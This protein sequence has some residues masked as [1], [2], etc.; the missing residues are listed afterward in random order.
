MP[1]H[2][3]RHF[4]RFTGRPGEHRALARGVLHQRDVVHLLDIAS[5]GALE[6]AAHGLSQKAVEIATP[7]GFPITN[8]MIVT[9]GVAILLVVFAQLSTRRMA[10]V[11]SGA[12]NLFEWLVE[13]LYGLLESILG[14][15]LVERTFWFSR[16]SSSSSSP[17]T[18]SVWSPASARSAGG[19]ARRTASSSSSRCCAARTPIS[20]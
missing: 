17:R 15:H 10:E 19:I 9:W 20:T 11:P 2:G 5:L 7:F 6:P 14:R 8:S 12:Q 18:G 1:E 3:R 16:P 4:P 13:G